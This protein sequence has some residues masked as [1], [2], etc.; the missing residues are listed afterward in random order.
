MY[1]ACYHDSETISKVLF[2]TSTESMT[3]YFTMWYEWVPDK[4]TKRT[5]GT[6]KD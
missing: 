3:L 4:L 1:V 5:Y 6:P 2:K